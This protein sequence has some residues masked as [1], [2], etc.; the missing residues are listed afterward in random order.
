[1]ELNCSPGDGKAEADAAARTVSV[2]L[3]PIK[4][5]EQPG[6]APFGCTRAVVPDRYHRFASLRRDG[7]IDLGIRGGVANCVTQDVLER[8]VKQVRITLDLQSLSGRN[9]QLTWPL[10]GF[11]SALID[12]LLNE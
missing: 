8:A 9:R 11:D 5:I 6:Q 1:M 2:R 12:H 10:V 4:R 7:E 3:D